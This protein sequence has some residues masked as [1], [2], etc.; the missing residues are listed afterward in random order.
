MIPNLV[1]PTVTPVYP[2]IQIHLPGNLR[3]D[4]RLRSIHQKGTSQ[5]LSGNIDG[6]PDI[7]KQG[8]LVMRNQMAS[9]V[10]QGPYR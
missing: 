10:K 7:P 4:H 2:I 9:K 3:R 8:S 6:M 1:G 5:N